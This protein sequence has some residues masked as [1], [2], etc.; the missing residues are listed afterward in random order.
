MV[1]DKPYEK[2]MDTIIEQLVA[3]EEAVFHLLQ[4]KCERKV[5]PWENSF[6][7]RTVKAL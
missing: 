5:K 7:T 1:G 3:S 6:L 4:V 2:F